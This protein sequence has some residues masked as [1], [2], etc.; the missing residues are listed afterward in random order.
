M[1][2]DLSLTEDKLVSF[3]EKNLPIVAAQEEKDREREEKEKEREER[4]LEREAK[5]ET[6]RVNA[7]AEKAKQEA[8]KQAQEN[9]KAMLEMKIQ[10][11][12]ERVKADQ[13]AM[14]LK[15]KA[16]QEAMEL[17]V[18]ADQEAMELELEMEKLKSE[19][20]LEHSRHESTRLEITN[21]PKPKMPFFDEKVDEMD[22]YLER[23]EWVAERCN[24][25]RGDWPYHLSQ[26]LRGKATEAYIRLSPTDRKNYTKVKEA[27]LERYNLTQEG[28][29]KKLRDADAYDDETP[30]QFHTRIMTYV[31]KWIE[32]SGG[33][34]LLELV[35]NEQFISSCPDDLAIH[36]RQNSYDDSKDM[37]EAASLFLHARG[38]KLANKK[39]TNTKR[40]EHQPPGN[41]DGGQGTLRQL[42]LQLF[43]TMLR[44][45]ISL[46]MKERQQRLR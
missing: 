32:L 6:Q 12:K 7:E 36:L 44:V 38:R 46:T 11:D 43:R 41:R 8:Q 37:C 21:K 35:S 18:K 3:I 24:W 23:F 13:E 31:Q 17:K 25:N 39:K 4:R 33:K 42:P 19:T 30:A 20:S 45:P 16:D 28:Y 29:R 9:E 27:L 10:A 34:D 22:S 14:E 5:L 2:K 26:Y 15:L 1:G 40:P